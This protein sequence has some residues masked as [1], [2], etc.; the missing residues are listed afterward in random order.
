MK[1]DELLLCLCIHLT[2]NAYSDLKVNVAEKQT[3]F[4]S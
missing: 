3:I 2:R 1:P 4:V